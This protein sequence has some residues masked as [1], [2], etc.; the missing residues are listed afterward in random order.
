MSRQD[1]LSYDP[2]AV[3]SEDDGADMQ[4]NELDLTDCFADAS[5]PPTPYIQSGTGWITHAKAHMFIHGCKRPANE[6]HAQTYGALSAPNRVETYLGM[7][8]LSIRCH[9]LRRCAVWKCLVAMRSFPLQ[10]HRTSHRKVSSYMDQI[11]KP[12]RKCTACCCT[13]KLLATPRKAAQE[14]LNHLDWI[15]EAGTPIRVFP[16][17]SLQY[18]ERK[19]A[20]LGLVIFDKADRDRSTPQWLGF[21]SSEEGSCGLGNHS[22]TTREATFYE[23]AYR[24]LVIGVQCAS[25]MQQGRNDLGDACGSVHVDWANRYC[26]VSSSAICNVGASVAF[27]IKVGATRVATKEIGFTM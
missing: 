22:P 21:H 4:D 6:V 2:W 9:V 8:G 17:N 27:M 14:V 12:G 16:F 25:A 24:L 19:P 7:L 1:P 13:E 5:A 3:S 18:L 26:E 23:Y 20:R 11:R 10:T 15:Q